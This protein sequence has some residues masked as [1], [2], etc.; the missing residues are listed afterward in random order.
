MVC[1]LYGDTPFLFL[2]I[3]MRNKTACFTGHR[4][5]SE[6]ERTRI[7]DELKAIV[8]KLINDG[9]S[10]FCAGGA[11]GFDT[12]AAQTVLNLKKEYPEIKLILVLPCYTQ[13]RGWNAENISIY[14]HIKSHADDV[15]YVSENYF[16]GCMQKRNRCLVDSSS[17]CICYLTKEIGGTFYTV[18]YAKK[19]ELRIFNIAE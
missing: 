8:E 9:Y 17:V 6:S 2:G 14:N 15:K 16:N 11:L 4:K 5:I 7:V 19:N 1:S 18:N 10:C 3:A 12:L 13:T